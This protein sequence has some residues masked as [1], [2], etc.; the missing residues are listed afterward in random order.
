[1]LDS[2]PSRRRPSFVVAVA[3]A[4]VT[5]AAG[6]AAPPTADGLAAAQRAAR[7]LHAATRAPGMALAVHDG[8]R[9]VWTLEL[10][11]ADLESGAPVTP[12]TRF[13][14]G[15]VSKLMTAAA[16]LRLAERGAFD[17]DAP[18]AALVPETPTAEPPITAR[19]L[20]GHLGGIRHYVRDDFGDPALQ[21]H[22]ATAAE[23]LRV[24]A[25][26]PLVARPGERYAYST[27]GYTLLA[28]QLERATGKPF[29]AVLADEVWGPLGLA[30][31]G[32]DRWRDVVPGRTRFYDLGE[33]G[34]IENSVFTDPSY[35]WAGGGMLSTARDLARFGA[36]FFAPGY[37]AAESWRTAVTTQH[38]GAGKET[39]VGFGWRV[40]RDPIRGRRIFHHAGNQEGARAVLVVYPDERLSIALLSNLGNTPAAALESALLLAEPLLPAANGPAAPAAGRYCS[41]LQPADGTARIVGELEVGGPTAPASG[42]WTTPAPLTEFSRRVGNPAAATVELIWTA[43]DL[44]AVATPAGLLP[45]RFERGAE[46]VTAQVKMP[47]FAGTLRLTPRPPAANGAA[48]EPCPAAP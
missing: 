6:L 29:G 25:D 42:A 12:A 45:L 35:K 11:V 41:I 27:F 4:A 15:S 40:D 8:E 21:R 28:A 7:A 23:S 44:A 37:L 26:D 30:E 48:P 17:L 14:L 24:F 34:G 32:L 36:A 18:T 9:L 47:G 10:G 13:R 20:A 19:L 31:S 43:P 33:G 5:A 16:A 39:G 1:M 38:D 3:V 2:L 22:Y 46:E